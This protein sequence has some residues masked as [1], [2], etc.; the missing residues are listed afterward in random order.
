MYS[1]VTACRVGVIEWLDK[2]VPLKELLDD[3]LTEAEQKLIQ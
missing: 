3:A 2:T 1:L